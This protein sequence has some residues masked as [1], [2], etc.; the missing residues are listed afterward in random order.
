MEARLELM[1]ASRRAFGWIGSSAVDVDGG[2]GWL[3]G[4]V[5]IDDLYS[6]TAGCCSA[7][8]KP[9][10]PGSTRRRST[11]D[12]VTWSNTEHTRTPPELPPEPGFMQGTAGIAAWL[13]RLHA[14]HTRPDTPAALTRLEPSWL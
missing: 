13:A 8:P 11:P 9:R 12:G 10:R 14:L 5:L 2:L 3:E 1:D 7:A 6:G 4:G